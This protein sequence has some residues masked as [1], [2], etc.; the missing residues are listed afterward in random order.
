MKTVLRG[1]VLKD[2]LT[3]STLVA[4]V[5][6][7]TFTLGSGLP[8]GKMGPFVHIAAAAS[9][10]LSNMI[11][12]VEGAYGNECRKSEMLAAACATGVA[13][14]FSAPVGG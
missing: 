4:K 10:V 5:V 3:M 6:S 12:K 13:C 1:V 9:N 2:F 11:A 8:I 14:T 7:L